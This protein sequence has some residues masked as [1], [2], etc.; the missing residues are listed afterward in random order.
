MA[1]YAQ[2]RAD[3]QAEEEKVGGVTPENLAILRE[4]IRGGS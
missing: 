3:A 1:R 2:Q 4:R